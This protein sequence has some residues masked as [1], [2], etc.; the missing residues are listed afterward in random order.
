MTPATF[1]T[2]LSDARPYNITSCSPVTCNLIYNPNSPAKYSGFKQAIFSHT[3]IPIFENSSNRVC[4]KQCWYTD[5]AD[6]SAT[7]RH[8]YNSASQINYLS[9]DINCSRWA[10]A[11]MELV[12]NF[13]QQESEVV[14]PPP[15]EMPQMHYV[16]VA[17]A[18]TDNNVHD[19]FLLKEVIDEK[20][21]GSFVKYIGNSST[22]PICLA[23]N[24]RAH[25]TKFLLFAQHLQYQKT[26]GLA[27]VADF[28]GIGAQSLP[29]VMY[30]SVSLYCRWSH[31]AY[32][33]TNDH[34]PVCL[35]YC[36]NIC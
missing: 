9:Q 15:F 8:L 36:Y 10:T 1:E 30:L 17:L 33:S 16:N 26:K 29:G 24:D 28:Q 14:S 12:Y 34:T 21:D 25:I 11:S 19:T 31:F 18:I 6:E 20:V 22:K 7:V 32:R 2:L 3:S 5:P 27:F 35:H 13:V 4:I 23:S